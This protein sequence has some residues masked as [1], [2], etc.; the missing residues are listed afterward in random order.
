[1]MAVDEQDLL[2]QL[3]SAAPQTSKP[4]LP[5]YHNMGVN[6]PINNKSSESG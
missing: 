6:S 5:A 2:D 3:K 4:S 1:M